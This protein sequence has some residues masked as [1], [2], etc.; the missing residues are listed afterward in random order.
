MLGV[1]HQLLGRELGASVAKYARQG[2]TLAERQVM[3][4]QFLDRWPG[5][6]RAIVYDV[7]AALLNPEG[8]SRNSYRLFLPFIDEPVV[9]G[10]VRDQNPSLPDRLVR[11]HMHAARF[12]EVT[13]ALAVRG[14]LGDWRSFKTGVIDD[15][16]LKR[17]TAPGVHRP[18]VFEPRQIEI[19]EATIREVRARGVTMILAF[20]PTINVYNEMQPEKFAAARALFAQ[21]GDGDPGVVYLE[22]LDGY[23]D[24]HE[25][26]YD[27]IHLN[28]AGQLLLTRQVARD[29]DR[30]MRARARTAER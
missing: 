11:R 19:L 10:Y 25:L 2:A 26:F 14:L 15:T 3:I 1:D 16:R 29:L 17:L 4:R 21:L 12:D 27:P 30:E 18:I 5:T 22:Y 23:A 20:Y 28:R 8:L 13:V 6:T 9:A 24:R 7:E